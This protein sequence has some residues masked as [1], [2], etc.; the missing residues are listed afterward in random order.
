VF[1][2]FS[3]PYL[4]KKVVGVFVDVF[5]CAASPLVLSPQSEFQFLYR[6]KSSQPDHIS[7]QINNFNRLTHIEYEDLPPSPMA[8][9]SRIN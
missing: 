6:N 1:A 4:D 7:S 8:A 9:A 2:S 5:R 3:P